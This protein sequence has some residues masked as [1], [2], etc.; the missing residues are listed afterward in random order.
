MSF[1]T[2]FKQILSHI[3][4]QGT[5]SQPRDMKV[6][7]VLLADFDIDPAK[8]IANFESRPFNWKYLAGN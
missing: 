6:K 4:E 8:P 3:K 2:T 7:E 1:S 5:E